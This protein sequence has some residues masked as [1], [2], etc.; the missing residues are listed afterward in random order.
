MKGRSMR[1]R[2]NFAE[3]GWPRK[4]TLL[5]GSSLS[6]YTFLHVYTLSPVYFFTNEFV[7]WKRL[8]A[9]TIKVC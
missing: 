7:A 6:T 3:E 5:L 4:S 8:T 1:L 2:L 9:A